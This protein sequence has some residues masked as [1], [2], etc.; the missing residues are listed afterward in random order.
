MQFENQP[1]RYRLPAGELEPRR[2][3]CSEESANYNADFHTNPFDNR[4]AGS[5]ARYF[6]GSADPIRLFADLSL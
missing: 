6:S 4:L 1:G 2:G 5:P 3:K